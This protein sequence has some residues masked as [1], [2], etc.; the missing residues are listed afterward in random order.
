MAPSKC[1]SGLA[2]SQLQLSKT[3]AGILLSAVLHWDMPATVHLCHVYISHTDS[4]GSQLQKMLGVAVGSSFCV[5]AHQVAAA[6][7]FTVVPLLKSDGVVENW[8]GAA[9]L[10][11]NLLDVSKAM[12]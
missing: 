1:V 6:A 2:C 11:F 12:G 9:T 7:S 8:E 5:H 10:E 3:Q 4:S